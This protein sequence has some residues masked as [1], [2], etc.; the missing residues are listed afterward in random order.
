MS[1]S[2]DWRMSDE[3]WRRVEPLLPC[4]E[5]SPKGGRPRLSLRCVT[6]G[7]FY[8]LRTGCQWK[9]LPAEFG[10]GSAVHEYYQAWTAAG[11]FERLWIA[12]LKEY[13]AL[14][15]I[16]WRWQSV[17]GAMTKSPLGEEKN[18]PESDG[19]RQIGRQA[20]SAHRRPRRALGRGRRRRQRA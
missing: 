14:R 16:A 18:R 3:L 9:A 2:A 20:V 5:P 8:V 17:D 10:S 13:D 12:C 4:Y 6:D 19:S 11:V 15:G 7:I 1:V